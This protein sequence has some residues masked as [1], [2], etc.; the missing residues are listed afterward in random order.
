MPYERMCFVC[1]QDCHPYH[2]KEP[3]VLQN[4]QMGSE[5]DDKLVREGLRSTV[6]LK[7][8][9]DDLI[10]KNYPTIISFFRSLEKAT[11][12]QKFFKRG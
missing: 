11:G 5:I 1:I 8:I 3:T 7:V 12:Y 10:G 2:G 6:E 9:S 4:N